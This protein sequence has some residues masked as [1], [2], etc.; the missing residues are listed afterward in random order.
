MMKKKTEKKS[1]YFV[2]IDDMYSFAL[3]FTHDSN[4]TSRIRYTNKGIFE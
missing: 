1:R 3:I 2:F 4:M